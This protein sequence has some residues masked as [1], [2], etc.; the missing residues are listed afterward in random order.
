MSGDLPIRLV[1][2]LLIG[3]MVTIVLTSLY[4]ARTNL[5][6]GRGDRRSAMRIA[7][8]IAGL[9][10]L[11]W[12]VNEHHVPTGWE[13]AL[14]STAVAMT[15]FQAG[16]IWVMYL[17]LEPAVRRRKSSILVSWTRLLAGQWRDP[18][19][20]RDVLIGCAVSVILGSLRRLSIVAPAWLGH[21]EGALL[22]R[23]IGYQFATGV[24]SGRLIDGLAFALVNGLVLVMLFVLLR[25]LSRSDQIAGILFVLVISTLLFASN[26]VPVILVPLI[27]LMGVSVLFVLLRFGL[28]SLVVIAMIDGFLIYPVTL[29]TSAW[30]AGYGYT[31][32]LLIAALT[33]YGFYT[34]LG[35]RRLR[36]LQDEE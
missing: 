26:P 25:I 1:F 5:R 27:I 10:G 34:S 4:L 20:G 8:F 7:L 18:L 9:A 14:I 30:Y 16:I 19:V 13:L 22:E 21:S 32:L 33:V 23:D 24:S 35:G 2:V 28:L 12:V 11:S 3:S 6:R 17:A 15:L 36:L 29:N 31:V